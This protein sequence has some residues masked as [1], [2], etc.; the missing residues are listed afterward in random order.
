MWV[1]G[2]DYIRNFEVGQ[3]MVERLVTALGESVALVDVGVCRL[4]GLDG[5]PLQR[6][7]V[8]VLGL[9][10]DANVVERIQRKHTR[11]GGR[12]TYLLSALQEIV[13]LKS[14][15]L[16]GE[17]NG[18]PFET[19]TFLFAVGLGR[20]FGKCCACFKRFTQVNIWIILRFTC[21]TDNT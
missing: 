3:S 15:Q 18:D 13:R 7:F 10:Y 12:I 19:D 6:I 1:L 2:C 11:I 20:F 5:E 21:C 17:V 8:N 14:H 16:K 9:G 4:Q